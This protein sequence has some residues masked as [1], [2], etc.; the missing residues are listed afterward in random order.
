MLEGTSRLY[1][2]FWNEANV[3][4][5]V[6]WLARINERP[7]VR[8]AF[9]HSRFQNAPGRARDAEKALRA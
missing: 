5:S 4:R 8:A 6:A 7:A 2:E 9:V 1:R 3:P